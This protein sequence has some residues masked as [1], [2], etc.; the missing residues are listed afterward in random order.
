MHKTY[1]RKRQA[2]VIVHTNRRPSMGSHRHPFASAEHASW[3]S[4]DHVLFR[5]EHTLVGRNTV[6]PKFVPLLH[7]PAMWS[8]DAWLVQ[9]KHLHGHY[10]YPLHSTQFVP[11][12]K[13]S[14]NPFHPF[15]LSA[16]LVLGRELVRGDWEGVLHGDRSASAPGFGCSLDDV[17]PSYG[18]N[19]I[20]F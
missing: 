14:Y 7:L 6:K 12:I 11:P 17:N 8:A 15:S 2:I 9:P 20:F 1:S 3:W 18:V 4:A 5:P 10:K 19:Q 13:P 16:S